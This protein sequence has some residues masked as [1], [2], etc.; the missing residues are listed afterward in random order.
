MQRVGFI[1]LPGFQ[2]MS[3]GALCVFEFA[4]KEVGEAVY[5]VQLL[6]EWVHPQLD[7]HQRRNG[8]VR[9]YELRH[10]DCRRQR[11]YRIVN[12]RR[13]QIYA[14]GSKAMRRVAAT[15]TGVRPGRSRLARWPTRDHA[16]EPRA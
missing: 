5:D 13:D 2:V 4:N 12:A 8:A 6:S 1:V 11:L 15:C 9:R 14:S 7:R 16:L 10:T 3:V